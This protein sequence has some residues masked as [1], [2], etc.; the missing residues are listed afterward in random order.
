MK[1]LFVF[2]FLIIAIIFG[3]IWNINKSLAQNNIKS[4][5]NEENYSEAYK[6]Y[7]KLSDEEK[8]KIE[9]I[10]RKYNV[11]L[12][13]LY[14]EEPKEKISLLQRIKR[15]VT[16][17]SD[18][19]ELDTYFNLREKIEIP[20]KDQE[21]YGLCWAFASI[22]SL[23]TNLALHGYGNY[24]FSEMHVAY[25]EK[26]GFGEP[27]NEDSGGWFSDFNHYLINN[28]GPVLEEE[29]PY[30]NYEEDEF[31]YIYNLESKAYLKEKTIDF[32]TIDKK[33]NTYTDEEL[34]LFRNKV[35]NHIMKNGSIYAAI[36]SHSINNINNNITIYNT[37]GGSNHA[38]SIVGWDDNFSKD[39][40][41]DDEG[42]H[43]N[44][45]GAYIALNSWGGEGD[46]IDRRDLIY[47]SYEDVTVESDMSGIVEAT[48][49][50]LEVTKTITFEDRNLYEAIKEIL[51][52]NVIEY[53]D[54]TMQIKCINLNYIDYLD[55][56]NK[57]IENLAGIENFTSLDSIYL[58]NNNITNIDLLWQMENLESIDVSKNNLE[59]LGNIS[60]N[61]KIKH[62]NISNNFL[63]DISEL[64]NLNNLVYLRATNNR[65]SNIDFI[66]ELNNLDLIEL[67][68]NNIEDVTNL[69]R[70]SSFDISGNPVKTGINEFINASSIILD[71][72]NLDNSIISTLAT[73]N[74]LTSISLRNNNITDVSALR[75][76]E[77]QYLDLSGNRNIKLNT[78]PLDGI[79]EVEVNAIGEEVGSII[80]YLILS[81]CN[82][83][84]ISDLEHLNASYLDLSNN[85]IE[86]LTPL[87][88]SN[89]KAINLN[90]TNV[91]DVSNLA[92]Y[93]GI[94]L[95]GNRN[96]TGLDRLENVESLELMNCNISDVSSLQNLDKL[97]YL[98]IDNNNITNINSLAN[99]TSLNEINLSHNNIKEIPIF[100]KDWMY[101]N[102]R[103]NNI[104]NINNL[105]EIEY[106]WFDLDYNC[107]SDIS[108]IRDDIGF[109]VTNQL[110]DTNIDV[111]IN[112][113][114][115]I[116]IPDIIKRAYKERYKNWGIRKIPY[117]IKTEF[118]T[119]NCEIDFKSGEINIKPSILGE[120][121]ATV[122]VVRGSYDGTI[123]TINYNAQENL[124]L[125]A[126]ELG[127]TPDK[128][129]YIEGE[130]FELGDTIIYEVFEGGVKQETND[131]T[132]INGENLSLG[133]EYV[134]IRSNKNPGLEININ[135]TVYANGDIVRV[136]FPDE[137]L[138]EQIK[139]GEGIV[140]N[141]DLYTEG[142]IIESD[143]DTN[144][145]LM[146]KELMD[147]VF[148]I[149]IN[150]YVEDISGL[151][152]FNNLNDIKLLK[153]NREIIEK[154]EELELPKFIYQALT[155]WNDN[156]VEAGI[157]YDT[158][159]YDVD[160]DKTPYINFNGNKKLVD[161][162]MDYENEKAYITLDNKKEEPQLLTSGVR[163]G[164]DG[165]PIKL[166]DIRGIKIKITGDK[167]DL[168]YTAFYKIYD[169]LDIEINNYSEEQEG[170][171]VYLVGINPNT[172]IE[173][174]KENIITNGSI[175]IIQD[176]D[177][178]IEVEE[179]KIATKMKMD[180]TR[181]EKTKE[182]I[183]IVT[184]DCTGDG[185]A[186]IKDMVRIN[187]YRLYGTITNFG[188]EYQKAA[189]VNKDGIINIKDMVRINNYRLYGTNL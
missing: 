140:S 137:V 116:I 139:Y 3:G 173:E 78:I 162:E 114:N 60:N 168:N 165:E 53:N 79:N 103:Y 47:I 126:I 176:E 31:E 95:S 86:D 10:P 48:L 84:D 81:D 100:N 85:S 89:I 113:D 110:F 43:P 164:P 134:T 32:P 88:N 57:G 62:L 181:G 94:Q 161:I 167:I 146:K 122:K 4:D 160:Y 44:N 156:S 154:K 5:D 118:E 152:Y 155:L 93:K 28:Y 22:R 106:G 19:E 135:I 8:K 143:D 127:K 163:G 51:G 108:E 67:Q 1:K 87:R 91:S 105:N 179:T 187:N 169:E 151:E 188:T 59:T 177:R 68:Y 136:N 145:L 41:L 148:G 46:G 29:A 119:T 75:N 83:T 109:S 74:N 26:N 144:S 66:T 170:E 90:N 102:L 97:Q 180:I 178:I 69:A 129:V 56:S 16:G 39:N 166:D 124:N 14:E 98:Y 34:R 174:F 171:I 128:F 99:M 33:Y 76:L 27:I 2:L 157:Y 132:I 37:T 36:N 25:I 71:D 115:K 182:Y 92:K 130:D 70:Y 49:N 6:E 42:N 23:E 35:K 104:T 45:D 107:I 11:P 17:S 133:Q 101:L 125:E 54:N 184:G 73:M 149:N 123:F 52:K 189:D 50:K 142:I 141:I 120:D 61:S 183:I 18:E 147:K 58:Y 30:R 38:I 186:N 13:M 21:S 63:E 138:Y 40:F 117:E 131:F 121:I 159:Y 82:I 55:L 15:F 77:L 150:Q 9:A 96:L 111:E 172:T 80:Y 12:D 64:Q 158:F 153:N 65:I 7:L 185:E 175:I 72:C 112:K 24:D 20:V